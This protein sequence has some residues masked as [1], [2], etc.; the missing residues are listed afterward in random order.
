MDK[1]KIYM[2][3]MEGL[4]GY[5]YRNAYHK[6][7][8]KA[9]RYFTPFL[10]NR[11]L[12]RRER[13]DVLPEH[14]GGMEV[15]PQI[16]TNQADLFCELEK[17]LYEY[18]Y[19]EVNLNLGCPSGTVTAKGRGAGFLAYPEALERFLDEI[20]S[21]TCMRIS[22]KTRIGCESAQEWPRL[23]TMFN[24]FPLSELIVHPRVRAD[25][26]GNTPRLE[27]Y[28][29]AVK[30]ST[31]RLCYN[32]DI[33]NTADMQRL[34]S[35]FPETE[36]VMLGRGLIANPG[37]AGEIRGEPPVDRSVFA[38]FHQELLEGYQKEMTGEKDVLFKMK[39]LWLYMSELFDREEIK[40]PLKQ[41]KKAGTIFE[42]E[43]AV[44]RIL[45][46]TDI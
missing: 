29:F 26:Y 7:F 31:C 19:R 39:E 21:K 9:D 40:K 41:I 30:N 5:V 22:I 17:I 20:F 35:E 43:C 38:A 32:G 36:Y 45:N 10:A 2:A 27:A 3:P 37:L 11:G 28:R 15:I 44:K 25:F 24:R 33:R 13:Q 23:L 12:N 42:Y 6:Y 16:L 4:T 8:S 1:L 18:G 46:R 14:N 34:K